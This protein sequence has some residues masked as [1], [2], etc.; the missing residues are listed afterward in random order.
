MTYRGIGVG[1]AFL[2]GLLVGVAMGTA[3]REPPLQSPPEASLTERRLLW[4]SY[5]GE[6]GRALE[7]EHRAVA[8]GLMAP[9][10]QRLVQQS[11]RGDAEE[12]H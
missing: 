10:L 8:T 5:Q 2:A 7:R 12:E 9:R 1:A 11:V 6:Q 4:Q 3:T